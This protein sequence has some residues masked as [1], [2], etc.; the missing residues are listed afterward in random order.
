MLQWI[1]R[2]GSDT[3]NRVDCTGRIASIPKL[4]DK[5]IAC[6]RSR[7]TLSVRKVDILLLVNLSGLSSNFCNEPGIRKRNYVVRNYVSCE[8]C[9]VVRNIM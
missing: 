6:S 9:T 1:L 5:V 3:V 2:V 8:K 7:V 4:R